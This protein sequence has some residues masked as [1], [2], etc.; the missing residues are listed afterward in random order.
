MKRLLASLALP[1]LVVGFV[2][3]VVVGLEKWLEKEAFQRQWWE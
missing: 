2:L 3:V 1:L